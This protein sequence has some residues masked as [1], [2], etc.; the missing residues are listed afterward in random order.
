MSK[1]SLNE[2]ELREICEDAF[3]NIKEACITLQEKTKCSNKV[4]VDML[5]NVIDFYTSKKLK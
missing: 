4:V 1:N 5:N 2:E 3:V